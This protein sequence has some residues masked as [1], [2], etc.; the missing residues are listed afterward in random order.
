MASSWVA[1]NSRAGDDIGNA[2]FCFDPG[3]FF[4]W[5]QSLEV[6]VP[7]A[8]IDGRQH[9]IWWGRQSELA[10]KT[11]YVS[12]SPADVDSV[13]RSINPANAADVADPYDDRRYQIAASF[14]TDPHRVDVFHFDFSRAPR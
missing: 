6:S 12:V 8:F 11:G 10:G 14:G 4:T 5:I 2:Y 7:P 3:T 1:R 9:F 13:K